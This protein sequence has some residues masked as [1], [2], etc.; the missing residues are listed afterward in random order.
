MAEVIEAR[1]VTGRD[2]WRF[3]FWGVLAATSTWLILQE[4]AAERQIRALKADPLWQGIALSVAPTPG[5]V[6]LALR[7]RF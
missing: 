6:Q 5:G 4:S 2:A 3:G 1:R 7:M